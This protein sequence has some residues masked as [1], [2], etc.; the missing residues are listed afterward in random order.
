MV[1]N[2]FIKRCELAKLGLKLAG[3]EGVGDKADMLFKSL[4]S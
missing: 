1:N 2:Q 3:T 4:C